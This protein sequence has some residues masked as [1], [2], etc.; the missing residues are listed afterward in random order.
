LTN[1]PDFRDLVGDEGEREELD[2]LRRVHDLLV[3]AG[4]PPELSPSLATPP[5]VEESKVLEFKRRR[6]AT[7]FALAAAIAVAAFFIGY[8]VAGKQNSFEQTRQL[9]MHG[10]GQLAAA[11]AEIKIG[12]HDVGGNYPL[13]M[14]VRG[15]PQLPRG[16]WYELLLSKHGRP[17]LSCGSFAVDGQNETI[18]MSVPFELTEFGKLYDGWV[19]VRHVPKNH[20]APVVMTTT[21]V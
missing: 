20:A 16:G 8:V 6:P 21:P 7:V 14:T 5:E 4:P 2:R 19:V 13:N 10:V 17:T 18:R 15:L 11:R 12:T 9:S 3:A 1:E